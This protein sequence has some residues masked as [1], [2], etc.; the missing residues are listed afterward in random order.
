MAG[1][2]SGA[3]ENLDLVADCHK[4][5][6]QVEAFYRE[7][8]GRQKIGREKARR[9]KE[10]GE[11]GG[12]GEKPEHGAQVL[13]EDVCEADRW[14]AE[15]KLGGL[16]GELEAGEAGIKPVRLRQ[17]CMRS[18]LD[19]PASVHDDNP[20]GCARGRQPVR[21]DDGGSRFHQPLERF[22]HQPLAMSIER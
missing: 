9:P 17:R 6:S 18:F 22:L 1:R 15:K 10:R 5:E 12:C 8:A 7:E 13:A 19:D 21:D 20:V 16:S 14:S 4:A 3:C 2:G 11:T